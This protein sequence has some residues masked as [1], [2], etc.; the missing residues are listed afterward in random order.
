MPFPLPIHVFQG[1]VDTWGLA[2]YSNQSILLDGGGTY[3]PYCLKMQRVCHFHSS[4]LQTCF[5]ARS[6]VWLA[7]GLSRAFTQH[8]YVLLDVLDYIFFFIVEKNL[9]CI[10]GW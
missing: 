3:P 9:S 1:H 6:L 4:S 8:N 7:F 5:R 10:T 2:S